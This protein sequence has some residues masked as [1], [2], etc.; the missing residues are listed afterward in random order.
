MA[1]GGRLPMGRVIVGP[2]S[3]G[4][5]VRRGTAPSSHCAPAGRGPQRRRGPARR[6]RGAGAE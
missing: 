1:V 5:D 6:G 4:L 3:A 2:S